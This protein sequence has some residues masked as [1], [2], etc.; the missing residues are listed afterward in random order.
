MCH[1][2]SLGV[3]NKRQS[4]SPTVSRNNQNFD[5]SVDGDFSNYGDSTSIFRKVLGRELSDSISFDIYL[6]CPMDF[7]TNTVGTEA[8][9]FV[10]LGLPAVNASDEFNTFVEPSTRVRR[11]HYGS[12][13]SMPGH[14]F[15]ETT[16]VAM[17]A[18]RS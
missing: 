10:N 8:P 3:L 9:N 17:S 5:A 18:T 6:R 16:L 14:V 2:G 12:H 1:S 7:T 11:P 13:W 4:M 15:G